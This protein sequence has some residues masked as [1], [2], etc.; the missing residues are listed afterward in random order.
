MT[1]PAS[2]PRPKILFLNDRLQH[3]G[4]AESVLLTMTR[5]LPAL[6][7]D[8]VVATLDPAPVIH[9]L[10]PCPVEVVP[11]RRVAS[12]HGIRCALQW[13][14]IVRRHK[15]DIVQ[16][17]SETSDLLGGPLARLAGA[18]ALISS[19]R[20]MGYRF[21]PRH[22]RAY[23]RFQGCFTQVHAV[24]DEVKRMCV[25]TLGFPEDKVHC[26]YNG[27]DLDAFDSAQSTVSP[28]ER[29]GFAPGR[30]LVLTVGN[31]RPVKG[32]DTFIE[33][34]ALLHTR[35]PDAAFIAIGAPSEP[36]HHAHLEHRIIQ[37]GLSD[38]VRLPGARTNIP[39][40]LASADLYCQLSRS[41]GF[42]NAL[43]EAMA[44]RL[45]CVATSV[46]GN[47]LMIESG[48]TGL[49]VPPEDAQAAANAI[50]SLLADDS[51]ARGYGAAARAKVEESFT[52]KK[53]FETLS[54]LYAR[55]LRPTRRS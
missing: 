46:G 7:Y 3:L 17:F 26:V 30:R 13:L 35:F 27:L 38:V 11:L 53:M 48:R 49:L 51:V 34:A 20:D 1:R 39:H 32:V 41:E 16:C 47:P 4:G 8:C 25:E 19:Q 37:L 52:Q 40:L 6:G 14:G 23:R 29:F 9:T 31:L 55:L 33:A 28:P 50:S 22:L 2:P 5:L 10:F 24:T 12:L 44:S 18:P 45:P 21:A 15:P 43:L 36:D 54:G 42:S